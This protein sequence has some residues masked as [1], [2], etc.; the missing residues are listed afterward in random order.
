MA[1]KVYGCSDDLVEV[2]GEKV[3]EEF[4]HI[5]PQ[6]N[7][8]GITIKFSDGTVLNVKYCGRVDGVW[9][10]KKIEVGSL[11]QGITECDDSEADIYSDIAYFKDGITSVAE[12]S[13]EG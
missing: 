2:E 13:K 8:P 11:F 1:T 7:D 12:L 6:E 3:N 5:G 9:E 4:D 10:V